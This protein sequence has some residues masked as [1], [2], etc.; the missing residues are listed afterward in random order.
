MR[1]KPKAHPADHRYPEVEDRLRSLAEPL[2][3]P[4]PGEWLAEH[5]EKG[6][7]FGQYLS[8]NP[9]RRG[10]G[11]TTIY[12]C[13]L[14][15]FT[16]RQERV[17]E[18]TRE[19]LTV[20]FDA[21]VRIRRRVP[22]SDIPAWAQRTHPEWGDEQLLT[23]FILRDVLGPDRPD[24][25]LAYLALTASDLWP[26]GGWNFLFGQADFRRR[27][28]VWS[29][30]RNGSPGKEG[31]AYRRCLWRTLHIAAHET[32][33]VLAMRH[34]TAFRC[35]M[36][37]CNSHQERDRQPLYPCPV[38]LRKL[39]WNLQAE[40]IPYLR[41]LEAFCREHGLEEAAWF[42]RAAGALQR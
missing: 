13:L 17:V 4:R 10:R 31:A 33:H 7:T 30:Y 40:P 14:G 9:V 22:L 16:G 12:L 28:G 6:Q 23:T 3:P 20:F 41:R 38:C 19:Y 32:G 27:T 29:L 11:L 21:P 1:R 18:L 2:P 8:A 24:D 15:G 34:C 25:A 26:G 36:N 35:L 42:G 37:G 5:R 39:V